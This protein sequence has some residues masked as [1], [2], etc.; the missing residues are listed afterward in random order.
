[1]AGRNPVSPRQRLSDPDLRR[2]SVHAG[3]FHDVELGSAVCR[4]GPRG[5]SGRAFD[6]SRC[7]WPGAKLLD[8]GSGRV[9]GNDIERHAVGVGG[10]DAGRHAHLDAH[11]AAQI[12]AVALL[13]DAGLRSK[14]K[15]MVGGAPVTQEFADA[16]GADCY[17][18]DAALAVDKAKELLKR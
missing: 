11:A 3:Y 13:A 9:V 6:Q 4:H 1:M 10:D 12:H 15:I 7:Q 2:Q 8:G 17:A 14:I 16:I 5:L 18:K